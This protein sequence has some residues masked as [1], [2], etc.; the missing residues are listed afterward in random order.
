M[1]FRKFANSKFVA[2]EKYYTKGLHSEFISSIPSHRHI[3]QYAFT[4]WIKLFAQSAGFEIV[5]GHSGNDSYFQFT[6]LE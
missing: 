6:K 1:D 2:G 4:Q 5:N 3:E